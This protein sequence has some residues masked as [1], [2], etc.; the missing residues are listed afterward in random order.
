M[1]NKIKK[2]LNCECPKPKAKKLVL[3]LMTVL[4][5]ISTVFAVVHTTLFLEDIAYESTVRQVNGL[6]LSGTI[7]TCYGYKKQCF[8]IKTLQLNWTI[9]GVSK[10]GHLS[11]SYLYA[12]TYSNM[13]EAEK[14]LDSF[15]GDT[16]V[17][18]YSTEDKDDSLYLWTKH[19][20]DMTELGPMIGWWIV[21][22]V[23]M[24]VTYPV[25][26]FVRRVVGAKSYKV[27]FVAA[28]HESD[29]ML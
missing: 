15:I 25:L 17:V 23:L 26:V 3:I 28:E 24:A 16:L 20:Q 29:P 13:T 4:I 8:E 27:V 14:G 21:V 5:I 22:A 9:D 7:G 18:Y 2:A 11:S 10:H 19:R 1:T 6:V 12:P